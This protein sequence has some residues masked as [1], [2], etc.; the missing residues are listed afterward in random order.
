MYSDIS[1]KSSSGLGV[2]FKLPVLICIGFLLAGCAHGLEP[3]MPSD[4]EFGSSVRQM[5]RGQILNTG[6]RPSDKP[7]L[8]VDGQKAEG[9]MKTYRG[10]DTK[11]ST[12]QGDMLGGI[13][14]K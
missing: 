2:V 3:D 8:G 13:L 10:G 1:Y 5:V 12:V 4:E 7:V 14:G 6:V 9:V 11:P